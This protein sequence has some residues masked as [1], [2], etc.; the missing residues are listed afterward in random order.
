MRNYF[1]DY[2]LYSSTS[3]LV[4][5]KRN[6]M[7][8]FSVKINA[9]CQVDGDFRVYLTSFLCLKM[10]DVGVEKNILLNCEAK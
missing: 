10:A 3:I 8:Y 6:N 1:C 2:A 7:Y 9:I 5:N 4:I